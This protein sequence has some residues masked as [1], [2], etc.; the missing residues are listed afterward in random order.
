MSSEAG[1]NFLYLDIPLRQLVA[2]KKIL[3]SGHIYLTKNVM[4]FVIIIVAM[5]SIA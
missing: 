5:N 2:I 4:D 1:S 3:N